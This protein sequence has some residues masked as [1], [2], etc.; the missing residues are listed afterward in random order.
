MRDIFRARS[1]IEQLNTHLDDL[2]L[3]S[4]NDIFPEY[5]QI[6][7]RT[8]YLHPLPLTISCRIG[9]SVIEYSCHA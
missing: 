3:D 8:K 5:S 9:G 4:E 7:G 6:E 1:D 2:R